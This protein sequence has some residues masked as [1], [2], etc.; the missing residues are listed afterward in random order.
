MHLIIRYGG[1]VVH[2]ADLQPGEYTIGR[3][4]ANKIRLHLSMLSRDHGKVYFA[5]DAW[6]YQDTRPTTR[7][8]RVRL[9]PSTVVELGNNVELATA[10]TLD[11]ERT[12]TD[13]ISD[14]R[15]AL[16]A[17]RGGPST[18]TKLSVAAVVVLTCA[19]AAGGWWWNEKRKPMD[20]PTL[21]TFA[22]SK[23]IE[24]EMPRETKGQKDFRKYAGLKDDDFSDFLG[25][26]TGFIIA[27]DTVL[28]A[29]HCLQGGMPFGAYGKFR[30][31]TH[32]GKLYDASRV[33]GF[34][35]KRDFAFIEVP[36]L[37]DYGHFEMS[38][39]TAVGD[40]VYTL[41][42]VAGEGIA[43]RDG[44]M[45]SKTP[46]KD[47]PTVE[48]L[49]YSAAASPGN[50]GGPLVDGHGRVVALVFARN[51]M[52]ENYNLGTPAKDLLAAKTRFVADQ[53]PK[54]VTMRIRDMLDFRTDSLL[55][56]LRIPYGDG[57]RENPESVRPLEAIEAEVEVPATLADFTASTVA[58]VNAATLAAYEKVANDAA[59]K[60]SG[61]DWLSLV[62][63]KSRFL[64]P[65]AFDGDD[66]L[67][68]TEGGKRLIDSVRMLTPP[69]P[70]AMKYMAALGE[71]SEEGRPFMVDAIATRLV[72]AK[73]K[74]KGDAEGGA[75]MAPPSTQPTG[76]E[77]EEEDEPEGS[78]TETS[79]FEKSSAGGASKLPADGELTFTSDDYG[80]KRQ[81]AMF[82]YRQL[83]TAHTRV[84]PVSGSD[85]AATRTVKAPVVLKDLVGKEGLIAAS[86]SPY[87]RPKSQRE[88]SI[89]ALEEEMKEEEIVDGVGRTWKVYSFQIFDSLHIE[90]YCLPL[91]QGHV[92]L[93]SAASIINDEADKAARQNFARFSLTP[94]LVGPTFWSVEALADYYEKGLAAQDPLMRDFKVT[95]NAAGDVDVQLVAM[96]L[97]VTWKA[98]Q[99]PTMLRLS[100]GVM[101]K[102]DA[103]SW[104]AAGLTAYFGGG[105]AK[106]EKKVC[107][108]GVEPK[109]A[110]TSSVA[111]NFRKREQFVRTMVKK[112]TKVKLADIALPTD[113]FWTTPLAEA[114]LGAP[115]TVYGFCAPLLVADSEEA[116][117]DVAI[118]SLKPWKP[119][120]KAL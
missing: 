28:T 79:A 61:T 8:G 73:D 51:S 14:I 120:Y 47:D 80:G 30:L 119:E 29:N 112:D 63:P 17:A 60:G 42:N 21:L 83:V 10:E 23:I 19:L 116:L 35:V 76:D 103:K 2:A 106:S 1:I 9:D 36:G 45:A 84:S 92:C 70:S 104:V 33:L 34:D 54:K 18:T 81:L 99:A 62:S 71:D 77:D 89:K 32:D 38:D 66:Q 56:A 109:G 59:N 82:A 97:N 115:A 6:W 37:K 78:A 88:F 67:E 44:L 27:P 58:A 52:S 69:S 26:C 55:Y 105:T 93:T 4:K 39:S 48:W 57:W 64:V 74:E 87:V 95:R 50:S 65:A 100:G 15:A 24:F 108:L 16:Q 75:P 49:R 113:R 85:W 101:Q 72:D 118:S 98:A 25:F 31:K 41:G 46:D 13:H 40:K 102:G 110:Y 94:Y 96:G 117:Y 91:P 20:A 11:S 5:E 114:K 111:H 68:A 3:G 12:K 7:G 86:E 90:T 53:S 107:D 43:I 22:K